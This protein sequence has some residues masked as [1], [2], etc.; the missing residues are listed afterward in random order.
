MT[1][2]RVGGGAG[3]GLTIVKGITEAHHGEVGVQS[4]L[5]K[6]STFTVTIPA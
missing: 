2:R 6:S 3:L 5:G 4:V 1:T